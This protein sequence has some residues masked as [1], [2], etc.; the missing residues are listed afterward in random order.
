MTRMDDSGSWFGFDDLFWLTL[1]VL[2]VSALTG[3]LLRRFRKN[4]CL[5]LFDNYHVTYISSAGRPLWG[6]LYVT[7]QG[8]ELLYDAP[9]TT[10]RGLV[11]S[12]HLVDANEI[13]SSLALCRTVHA[14][15]DEEKAHR[16]RQIRR[17]FSPG[18]VRR[19]VRKVR[20]FINMMRDA[21][22]SFIG[23]FVGAMGGRLGAAVTSRK[24][25]VSELSETLVGALPNAYEPLLERHIGKPVVVECSTAPGAVEPSTEFAGYLVEYTEQ[26]IAVFSVDQTPE[27]HLELSITEAQQHEGFV[28][29]LSDGHVVFTCTGP[30][31][32]IVRSVESGE[33]LVDLDVT[34]LPGCSLGIN[35]G[36]ADTV[37]ATVE[38]THQLDI[39]CPR[40]NARV[41]FSSEAGMTKAGWQGVAPESLDPELEVAE[42]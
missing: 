16:L 17:T 11:K 4:G 31:A 38:L 41:R 18:I 6:D 30:N 39:V 19:G 40:A 26:F 36:T 20:N 33:S 14:L 8:V 10:S 13:R 22:A 35:V 42:G 3:A 28:V 1:L 12:S 9:F 7:S 37:L 2:F 34:L 27:E 32:L 29:D 25:D 24:A 5:K 21:V 23:L 15:T